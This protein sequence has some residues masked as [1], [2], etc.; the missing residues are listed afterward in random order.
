LSL[1]GSHPDNKQD[2]RSY[3][4]LNSLCPAIP[5]WAVTAKESS[6]EKRSCTRNQPRRKK[7]ERA[8]NEKG[9]R[10]RGDPLMAFGITLNFANGRERH[11]ATA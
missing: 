9:N 7:H 2:A 5:G 6:Y 3:G 1:L 8:W 10:N 4:D 11:F